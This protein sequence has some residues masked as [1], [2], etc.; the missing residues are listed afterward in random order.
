MMKT[1]DK[2]CIIGIMDESKE[3]KTDE[4]FKWKEIY[5]RSYFEDTDEACDSNHGIVISWDFI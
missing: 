4:E 3:I 5:K 1:Y 2:P